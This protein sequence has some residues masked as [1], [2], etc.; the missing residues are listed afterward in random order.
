M[1]SYT[2]GEN[3]RLLTQRNKFRDPQHASMKNRIKHIYYTSRVYQQDH[4]AGPQ[5][6]DFGT[7][8]DDHFLSSHFAF[9]TRA[10]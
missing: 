6:K 5:T 1:S 4:T 7:K 2:K 10:A 9:S 8:L 3:P